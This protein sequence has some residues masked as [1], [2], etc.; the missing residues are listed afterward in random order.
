MFNQQ[1]RYRVPK[2]VDE[3]ADLLISDLPAS[4]RDTLAEMSEE[5]FD[6]MYALVAGFILE[7]FDIWTGNDKLLTSCF[8]S[9]NNTENLTDPALIILKRVRQKLVTAH[10][11]VIIT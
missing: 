2:T 7:E 4:H 6:Q 3:A 9:E 1:K 5:D 11:I 10:G 8:A